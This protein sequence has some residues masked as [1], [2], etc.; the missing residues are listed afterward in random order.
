MDRATNAIEEGQR[1]VIGIT[2]GDINGIGPEI[3]IKSL[4]DPRILKLFTPVIY[5]S[6]KVLAYYKKA[7]KAEEFN[8]TQ[9]KSPDQI[10]HRKINV[11][12]C[13]DD[14]VE[15][16]VGAVTKE[17]GTSAFLALEKACLDLKNGHLHAI[18]TAPIN[19]NNIQNENF[20]FPGHTEYLTQY[21]GTKES[22]MFLVSEDL[23]V[24]VVTGHIPLQEV[25]SKLS[26]DTI[27][28]KIKIM[29]Q[30]LRL[31]FGIQKPKIAVLGLNPHAGE[32]GLLG[33]EESDIIK[34][35]LDACKEKGMLV[36]GPFASDGFFGTSQYKKVD[37]V[38]AMYHDQGLIPFKT[39]AF[40]SGVNFTA[41]LPV[42]RTSPDHGTAYN[43][44][45]K[46]LASE[47]SMREA[48]FLAVDIIKNR[49]DS[50]KN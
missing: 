2:V 11:V 1:P 5:G 14:L 8:Y 31:D 25:A 26:T 21:F 9:I 44:A 13:W 12:N 43:I 45:G 38:L 37:A 33:K 6:S 36:Y 41:G 7:I 27:V 22:L 24:G 23:R 49:L 18:V 32:E 4:S 46:N 29:H 35:A 16:N 15:I 3:I 42:I 39:L 10:L 34:P 50:R 28:Q 19:K 48:I 30:S 40:E 20:Q 47:N 17:A